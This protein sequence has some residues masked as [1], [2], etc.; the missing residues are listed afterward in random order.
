MAIKTLGGSLSG[1][2]FTYD[3]GPTVPVAVLNLMASLDSR[4]VRFQQNNDRLR[5]YREDGGDITYEA[6]ERD[7]IVR[8]KSHIL[9]VVSLIESVQEH[10]KEP[11]RY[12]KPGPPKRGRKTS[13]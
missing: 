10:V 4:G 3:S 7:L 13:T 11:S 12:E 5:V 1:E 9:A 6:G 2:L 8:Y